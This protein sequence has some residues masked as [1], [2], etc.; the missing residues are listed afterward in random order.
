M[1]VKKRLVRKATMMQK[2]DKVLLY[3]REC[4]G[5]GNNNVCNCR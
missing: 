3:N 1:R 5:S 4:T 2:K